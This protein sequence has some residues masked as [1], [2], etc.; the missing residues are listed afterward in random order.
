M[1][2]VV[3]YADVEAM[4]A[5]ALMAG[6]SQGTS[7]RMNRQANRAQQD[8]Q[9]LVNYQMG[10]QNQVGQEN[11]MRDVANTRAG[12]DRYQ[13]DARYAGDMAQN[14]A[15]QQ[16][17]QQRLSQQ[18]QMSEQEWAQRQQLAQQ[19]QQGSL[20][21]IAARGEQ[22]RISEQFKS[23][24]PGSGGVDLVQRDGQRRD[25][26]FKQWDEEVGSAILQQQGPDAYKQ[27]AT[28]AKSHFFG[29]QGLDADIFEPRG[30][31]DQEYKGFGVSPV[32]PD[33]RAMVGILQSGQYDM[34]NQFMETR[35]PRQDQAAISASVPGAARYAFENMPLQMLQ[36][37]LANPELRSK[38]PPQVMAVAEQVVRERQAQPYPGGFA[39]VNQPQQG[40][41]QFSTPM[42]GM[43]GQQ[44]SR[45]PV[46]TPERLSNDELA[47]QLRASGMTDEQ[48]ARRYPGILPGT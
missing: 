48:I 11:A 47:E 27:A 38:M 5:L 12:A 7:N 26:A 15:R 21:E 43:P 25:A 32:G 46:P 10:R 28:R 37:Q 20:A 4:G 35:R 18:Q 14:Q 3:S 23:T 29:S 16:F 19:Q 6:Q 45:G 30:Q 34:L 36:M 13:A 24:L 2:I 31:G 17:E 44:S 22:E 42:P 8:L 40:Q 1:P 41:Q 39:P 9:M 33:A